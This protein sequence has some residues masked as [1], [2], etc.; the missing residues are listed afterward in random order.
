MVAA[1]T[2]MALVAHVMVLGLGH[3]AFGMGSIGVMLSRHTD[4]T[5]RVPIY[6]RGRAMSMMGGSMRLS[7][8]VGTATG[9][10]LVETVGGRWT[11]AAAG[12]AA[13]IGLPAVIPTAR[14][15]EREV[16]PTGSGGPGLAAVVRRHHRQ[17]VRVGVFGALAMATREGR[18]VLLPLVG[19]SLDLR[20][21]AIGVL[22]AAGYAADL[23]LF[24]VSGYVMDRLGRLSAMVPAYGL[25]AVGLLLLASADTTTG[26]LVAGLVMGVGNG[27]SSGSLFT[28]QSDVSPA[29][30]TA[31]FLA[32]ATVATDSGRML[33]PLLVGLVAASAGLAWAAVALAVVMALGVLWLA[34]VVGETSDPP[35]GD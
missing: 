21:S 17:L 9:G 2:T 18:M 30:G 34:L 32:A 27:L 1:S 10:V 5:R 14:R 33:G 22:V 4:L 26:V 35:T 31:S 11:I 28:L 8:M 19:V 6:L 15:P 7:V 16:A 24:P 3:L 23:L 29:E 25:L 12:L 20:P 13:A